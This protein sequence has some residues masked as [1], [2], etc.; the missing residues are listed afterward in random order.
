[1]PIDASI[2]NNIQQP[3]PVNLLAQYA[4]LAQ[5]QGAQQAN[6]LNRLRFD[7]YQREQDEGS[8]MNA[9]YAGAVGPDGTLDR[10]K[11]IS[12]A[13]TGGL[14]AKIPGM[15][16]SFAESDKAATESDAAKFKLANDRYKLFQGTLGALS[17]EPN[18]SK[19]LVLQ[20]GQ[21]LVQQGLLPQAMFAQT[22]ATLP[23]DPA[24][25]RARLLQGMK[26][27]LPP[28][29][30]FELFAPKAEK[31]DNGATLSF[32]DMNPNSP[33]YGQAT[34]GA[35]VQKQA[36]PGAV[37]SAQTARRGQDMTDSRAREFNAVQQDANNI[38][39]SEARATQDLTKN[40]QIASFDTML[41]TLDR[42]AVHPGLSR[43]VGVIGALPTMPGSDSANFQAELNTFQSQAFL[44]MVAQLKGMGALSDAEGKK[45]TAAV[46]A[47]DPKMGEKAFRESVGRITADMEAARARMAGDRSAGARPSV[48]A[49][50][51]KPGMVQ[52]GYRFKGG[53]PADPK[54]WEKQ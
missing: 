36:D 31:I 52:D 49:S 19:E 37:L 35:P 23:D 22:A 11:L 45:L 43:S 41:G 3:K 15:Q 8:R 13:A 40:S 47:L 2:Y 28:E 21:S 29:K 42:L 18:L 20:A 34:A 27:Q 16:K 25:L 38:K 6:Q 44:P 17:Q 48:Q 5:L 33:T 14:G 7:A 1:M 39:R 10:S 50:V 12:G 9:L 54:S 26:T 24:Q 4:D 30:V 53:N 46:G 51:P 32:R